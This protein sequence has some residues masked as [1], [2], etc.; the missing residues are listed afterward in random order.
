MS[1]MSRLQALRYDFMGAPLELES[2]ARDPFSQFQ[3][4]FDEVLEAKVGEPNSMT[5]ATADASGKPGARIVLLKDF[6]EQGFVFFTNY[7]SRKGKELSD[8]PKATLLFFWAELFRQVTIEGVVEKIAR[9]ESEEYYH[10]RPRDAQV[11][12]W[13]SNQS[14]VLSSRAELEE[15]YQKYEHEFEGKEVP[16]PDFWGGYRV[17]PAR[18][19]FWQGRESR[20]H[21]RFVYTRDDEGAWDIDRLNP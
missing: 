17:I 3:K 10:T 19:E 20:L 9:G 5:L 21:D 16:L 11:G 7:D 6:D 15:R 13:A 8:N 12:A 14:E 2:L 18:I 1:Q 4:W